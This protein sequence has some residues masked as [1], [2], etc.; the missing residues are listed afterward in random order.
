MKA[1]LAENIAVQLAH[2]ETETTFEDH[3][4]VKIKGPDGK[5]LAESSNFQHN[6]F[7][8]TWK[9]RLRKLMLMAKAAGLDSISDMGKAEMMPGQTSSEEVEAGV[10]QAE[11][12]KAEEAPMEVEAP[13]V[14]EAVLEPEA[15]AASKEAP[16]EAEAPKA[17]EAATEAK[18]SGEEVYLV[19]ESCEEAREGSKDAPSER[20]TN[21]PSDLC[22]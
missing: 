5:V 2:V 4:F 10:D 17:A 19:K 16:K 18:E 13:R 3:G 6:P 15:K 22:A 7:G 1:L 21:A 14:V 9:D 20:S 8:S 12:P 11:A